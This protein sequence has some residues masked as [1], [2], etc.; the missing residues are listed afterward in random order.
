MRQCGRCGLRCRPGTLALGENVNPNTGFL[1]LEFRPAAWLPWKNFE[2]C[3]RCDPEKFVDNV[4]HKNYTHIL[5]QSPV[6]PVPPAR[7]TASNHCV[8][9]DRLQ[10]PIDCFDNAPITA[11]EI[12]WLLHVRPALSKLVGQF[13]S[14]CGVFYR[15]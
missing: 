1:V 13:E 12:L 14:L 8:S 5:C 10:Q 7:P 15:N 4:S 2:S 3:N 11:R 9:C 6:V